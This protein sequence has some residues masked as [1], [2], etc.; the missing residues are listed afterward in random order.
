VVNNT[1]ADNQYPQGLPDGLRQ[2]WD[3]QSDEHGGDEQRF[4]W[5]VSKRLA[6]S[7]HADAQ[8]WTE[9]RETYDKALARPGIRFPE[10]PV[11]EAQSYE[12]WLARHYLNEA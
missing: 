1:E 4:R 9:Y 6:C 3:T 12:D 11:F 2:M 7:A 5:L 8:R 10:Y